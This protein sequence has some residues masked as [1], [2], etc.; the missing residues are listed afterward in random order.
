MPTVFP[1]FTPSSSSPG[2]FLPQ[3]S[4]IFS[5]AQTARSQVVIGPSPRT[6]AIV[7]EPLGVVSPMFPNVPPPAFTSMKYLLPEP[8]WITEPQLLTTVF[9]PTAPLVSPDALGPATF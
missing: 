2:P 5:P 6:D 3:P 8:Q 4:Q 1:S 9:T 7:Y